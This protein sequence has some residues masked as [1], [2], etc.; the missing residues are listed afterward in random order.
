MAML[1]A[2]L[3]TLYTHMHAIVIIII[4]NSTC[5]RKHVPY[6]VSLHASK[7]TGVHRLKSESGGSS[8]SRSEMP[9]VA[10]KT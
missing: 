2:G 7:F 4:Y 8:D 9:N 1:M 3:D 10:S 6:R 5:A